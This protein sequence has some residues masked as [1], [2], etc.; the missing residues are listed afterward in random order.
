[1]TPPPR[2]HVLEESGGRRLATGIRQAVHQPAAPFNF[3]YNKTDKRDGGERERE[4]II[5]RKYVKIIFEPVIMIS[6]RFIITSTLV[7]SRII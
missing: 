5:G 7:T 6:L 2:G 4:R 1:M 3:N